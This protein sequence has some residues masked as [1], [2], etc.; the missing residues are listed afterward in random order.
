MTPTLYIMVRRDIPDMNPGKACAQSAHAQA[1]FDQYMN[2]EAG[3]ESLNNWLSWKQDRT[4]GRTLV[5]TA[6]LNEIH[7]VVS[8]VSIS[9]ITTDPTYPWKN[10]WGETFLTSEQTVGWAFP[11]N[12][13]ETEFLKSL[14]LHK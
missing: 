6:T 12:E 7:D 13:Y 1:D 14:P 2:E 11:V 4:F 10:Y 8:Q 3:L 5:V 9:G